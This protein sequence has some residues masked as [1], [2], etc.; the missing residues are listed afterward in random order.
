[1]LET[2]KRAKAYGLYLDVLQEPHALIGGVFVKCFGY[3]Y[4]GTD[5][6]LGGGA[7]SEETDLYGCDPEGY[8]SLVTTPLTLCFPAT[9]I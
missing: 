5:L 9:M 7:W 2:T 4:I 1:M 3:Q 8:I 6:L